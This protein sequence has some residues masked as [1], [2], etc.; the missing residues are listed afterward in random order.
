M[1]MTATAMLRE[2]AVM[3]LWMMGPLAVLLSWRARN[4]VRFVAQQSLIFVAVWVALGVPAVMALRA[5]ALADRTWVTI[6]LLVTAA[7]FQFSRRHIKE[8]NHCMDVPSDDAS[9]AVQTAWSCFVSCGPLMLA[10]FAWMPQSQLVMGVAAIAMF[11]EFALPQRLIV[12]R[13]IGLTTGVLALGMMFL[14]TSII[15]SGTHPAHVHSHSA[16]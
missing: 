8:L 14:G 10:L 2:W 4:N 15:P 1:P 13:A 5:L 12:A 11:A 9:F 16:S 7:A 6:A 3:S